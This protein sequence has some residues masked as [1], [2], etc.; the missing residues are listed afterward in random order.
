[1]R[2]FLVEVATFLTLTVAIPVAAEIALRTLDVRTEA[3]VFTPGTSD[4]GTRVMRLSWNPQFRVAQPAD[5]QR[6]FA[7]VKAPGTF[8]IFVI[9]ESPAAGS[10][11]GTDLAFAATLQHRLA[12]EAP[13]VHWEV[14]NAA[15][16]GLQTWSALTIVRDI[17]R[18][19]PDLLVVYMGH[20][21]TGT[22]FTPSERRWID[23]RGLAWRARLVDTRLYEALS[24]I[25]PARAASQMIDLHNVHR[26][27]NAAPSAE[28]RRTFATPADRALSAAL[29]R[30]RLDE[31]VRI[32]RAAGA[33]TML[34]TLSQN[35]S[36]WGPA[37]STHRRGMRPD[38]KAAWRA[39]VRAGDAL[40]PED[41]AGA[42]AVWSHALELDDGYA[43]LQFK[44]ATCER[45]L[46]RLEEATTRFRRAN[47]LDALPQGAPTSFNDILRAVARRDGAIL[48]DIDLDF[49]QVSGPRLVGNDLF[50]DP[51][52][53]NLRGHQVIAAAV[54]SAIRESGLA[55]PDVRWTPGAYVD[56]DPEVILA[57][58][59]ELRDRERFAR[60][61]MCTAAGRTDCTR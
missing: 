22:R 42:L 43:A 12:A 28:G 17:A 56:P 15:L 3:A 33:H 14:V 32:M 27:G 37:A 35:F 18:Y 16:A 26:A 1:M 44:M 31:M 39:A 52:H 54:A 13:A 6:E 50:I 8:R 24:R 60:K 2:R 10:P 57:G 47:D 4:D 20:N 61:M 40:A 23:P 9:G 46:G 41:C 59:P 19:Q 7:A 34:L 55:G 5:P 11:Y 48:V 21:E 29:Y 36:D 30:S 38:E 51:E 58:T 45:R 53:L 25:L 49:R